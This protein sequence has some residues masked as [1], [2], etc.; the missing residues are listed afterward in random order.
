MINVK[1]IKWQA[2]HKKIQMVNKTANKGSQ[3]TKSQA[4]IR[5][6][7]STSQDNLMIISVTS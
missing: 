7:L 4:N 5:H 6:I 3:D 1:V 2:Q